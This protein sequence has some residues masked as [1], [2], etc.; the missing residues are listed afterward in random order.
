MRALIVE[1][2][3]R[4]AAALKRIFED[5]AFVTDVVYDGKSGVEYALCA[6]YDI[7][8]LDIMLPDIDGFEVVQTIRSKKVSTPVL[9]LTA[10]DSVPDKVNGL[11]AGAD[12][13]MTKPFA[14]EE[15]IAR[16]H[17]LTRRS[18]EV[19]LDELAYADITLDLTGCDLKKENASV[20]LSPKEFEVMRLLMNNPKSAVLKE[21]LILNVWGAESGV[22]DNNLEAYISFLRR[23][24]R[25]LNSSV[26]I[27]N[28]QK[29]GYRLSQEEG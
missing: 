21:T 9:M 15:L 8:L 6:P 5:Q 17:A 22:E 27:K 1:D 19:V 16:I 7:I 23:K 4:L 14:T 25:F 29:I 13:Y 20:H 24:L 11:N 12:D 28:L 10:K 3:K 2:E 18:G 26:T